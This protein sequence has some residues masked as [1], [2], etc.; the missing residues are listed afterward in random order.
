MVVL[1]KR[2]GSIF[3]ILVFR[4]GSCKG[5]E[6]I[7]H[8]IQAVD[9]LGEQIKKQCELDFWGNFTGD[10]R[11]VNAETTHKALPQMVMAEFVDFQKNSLQI[12]C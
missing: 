1:W 3:V 10:E 9:V 4:V 8:E 12:R 11:N 7:V 5:Y 2:R 6:W